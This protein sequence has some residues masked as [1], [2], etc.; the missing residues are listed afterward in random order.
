MSSSIV[1]VLL[2]L[3]FTCL[4]CVD[5]TDKRNETTIEYLFS[6]KT[7]NKQRVKYQQKE[8]DNEETSNISI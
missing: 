7:K 5:T 8:E 1:V 2:L 4:L 6:A 3:F